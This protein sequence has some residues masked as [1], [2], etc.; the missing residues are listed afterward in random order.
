MK[1]S[2]DDVTIVPQFTTVPSRGDERL[3][4]YDVMGKLPIISSN[5]DSVTNASM[6]RA[7]NFHN[8]HAALH[9]FCP[10]DE[11]VAMF[12]NS[13]LD[14]FVSIGVGEKELER[15]KALYAAG[16]TKFIID[17]AHGASI[18]VAEQTK[19]VR[20]IIGPYSYLVVGNFATAKSINT[21]MKYAGVKVDAVKV[22]IGGG[23]ACT[24]RVVTG[25]GL[26]TLSSVLDC[27]LQPIPI[28][29]DGGCRTSGDIVKALVAGADFVMLGGMLAGCI[30]SAG[31]LVKNELG[32]FKRYRGS[33]SA[34]SYAVQNKEAPWR[35][36]E[37]EAFDTPVSAPVKDVLQTIEGGIRSAMGFVNAYNLQQLR[38]NSE[39]S[40][41]TTAGAI[42]SRA[43]GNQ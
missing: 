38:A 20:E 22:G 8:A 15:A 33:A 2:F 32:H 28:I 5:M 37:G 14:T 31:E 4:P 27:A 1:L 13:P 30:E 21:F 3:N 36:P 10:I 39:L 23:S 35:A 19:L 29:A 41:M 40:I 26:P 18:I 24:T 42:E 6:A 9:R 34:E 7:M 43:H 17:V 16:A 25:C 12:R 11:N